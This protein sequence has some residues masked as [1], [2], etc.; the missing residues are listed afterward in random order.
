M[1]SPRISVI[2][3]T[4]NHSNSLKK[5]IAS[6]VSQ[7]VS[8]E[9][10]EVLII[11]NG[12][13]DNTKE[14]VEELTKENSKY[15]IR[16]IYE[17]IPG[18]L[19]GRHRGALEAKGDIL[20]FIDDDV[21]VDKNWLQAFKDTFK[22]Y[23]SAQ[24]V[25]GKNL[26]KFEVDPPEWILRMWNKNKPYKILGELSILDLG[27]EEREVSPL[28]VWGLNFSIRKSALFELGGFHPDGYP[29]H[30]LHFR[31][32]GETGIA[33]KS[34]E[35][36]LKAIYQPKA[37]VYHIIPSDRLTIEYFEM[38]YVIQG[39]SDSY[40]AIRKRYGKYRS[41]NSVRE[42]IKAL[43]RLIRWK[44]KI[45]MLKFS[46]KEEDKT[47]LRFRQAWLKG[48]NFH[49]NMVKENP[50]LLKWVLRD[51]YFDYRLPEL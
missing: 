3:S 31:G 14:V 16:C 39:I 41:E 20:V 1:N 8:S 49:Q 37:L 24:V 2:T 5:T 27:D 28:Y 17:P 29:K 25:G 32:D 48:Y 42:N 7:T 13:T 45:N 18:L 19:S 10:F 11:D 38:R 47:M 4:R 33:L 6:V 22:K 44:I 35:K 9:E 50:E 46:R 15:T 12:S 26:P 23:P 36:G 21:E 51:N 40:T 30:L 43:L 34:M